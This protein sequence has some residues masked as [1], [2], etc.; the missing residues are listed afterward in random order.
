MGGFNGPNLRAFEVILTSNSAR[1]FMGRR[2]FI[3]ELEHIAPFY[4]EQ[5]GQHLQAWK[6]TPPKPKYSVAS[7]LDA[8]TAIDEGVEVPRA[9]NVHHD[10]LEI[11]DFLKRIQIIA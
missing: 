10:L 4:Y 2:T 11:P 9:G 5:V 3:E 8:Q 7:E 1:R 6:A